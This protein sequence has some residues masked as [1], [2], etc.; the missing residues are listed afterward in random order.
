MTHG[1]SAAYAKM[2]G[3]RQNISSVIVCVFSDQIH[4]S[5][6]KTDGIGRQVI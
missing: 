1:S 3:D 4:S 2:Y 5:W 6:R